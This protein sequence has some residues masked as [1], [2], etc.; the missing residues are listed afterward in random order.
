MISQPHIKHSTFCIAE[1]RRYEHEWYEQ[2]RKNN[3]EAFKEW[4]RSKNI[5]GKVSFYVSGFMVFSKPFNSKYERKQIIEGFAKICKV[6][7]EISIIRSE[8]I[9]DSKPLKALE[10]FF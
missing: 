1:R 6:P 10:V 5:R 9:K 2:W 7:Y 3:P 4:N 8:A